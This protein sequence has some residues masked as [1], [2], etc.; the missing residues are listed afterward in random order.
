[1]FNSDMKVRIRQSRSLRFYY[2]DL[3]VVCQPNPDADLF[4]DR[5][6]VVV[7]MLSESTRRVDE[8]EKREAYLT[9]NSLNCY[10]LLEQDVP[11]AVMYRRG[12]NGFERE[13][14]E[15]LEAVI[16]LHEIACEF[17]LAEAYT[18]V[19]FPVTE[20]GDNS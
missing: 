17:S 6:V 18:N 7:E 19:T 10:L 11:A 1:V 8:Y 2:P 5:P 15:G 13:D 3:S 9:I 14:Y 12:D 20:P 16:Q 4:Q